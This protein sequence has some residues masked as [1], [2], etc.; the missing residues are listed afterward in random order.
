M[1]LASLKLRKSE[2]WKQQ[3][4]QCSREEEQSVLCQKIRTCR[5]SSACRAKLPFD[6]VEWASNGKWHMVVWFETASNGFLCKEASQR[7]MWNAMEKG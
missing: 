3:V 4:M 1:Q 7:Y 2:R 5:V 6:L